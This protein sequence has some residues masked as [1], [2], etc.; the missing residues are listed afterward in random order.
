MKI[1]NPFVKILFYAVGVP[2][3]FFVVIWIGI[4]YSNNPLVCALP[5][6]APLAF[7]I[8]KAIQWQIRKNRAVKANSG[9]SVQ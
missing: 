6:L 4:L 8:Y 2:I 9:D 1:E 5:V 7:I 3:I